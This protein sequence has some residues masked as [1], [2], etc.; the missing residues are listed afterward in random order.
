MALYAPLSLLLLPAAWLIL[1]CTGY[2]AMFWSVGVRPIRAAFAVSGSSLFTLGFSAPATLPQHALAFTEAGLGI[3]TLALLITYLPSLYASFSR[4]ETLVST[5]ETFA[6]TPASAAEMLRRFTVI[7]GLDR[8]DEVWADWSTWF[9]QIEESHASAPSLV[10][11]RSPQPDRSWVVAAGAVLDAASLVA[12]CLP[13]RHPR[14]ELCV[15]S[16]YVCLRSIADYFWLPYPRDLTA[17]DPA[18]PSRITIRREEFDAVWDRLAGAGAPLVDD[19]DQAWRDFAGWRV[20]YDAVLLALCS[21]TM[22][23]FAPWSSDRAP[24]LPQPRLF[25]PR[26]R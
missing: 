19:R 21:L 15:R 17:G 23:P 1:I 16:G 24:T 20:N 6:G 18:H 26:R 4:R 8:L 12:A 7:H 2:V 9:A 14:A 11:F 25:R 22:A 13:E 3:G 5:L 10:F